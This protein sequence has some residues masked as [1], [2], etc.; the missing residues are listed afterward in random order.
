MPTKK[1]PKDWPEEDF[2]TRRIMCSGGMVK[3]VHRISS[4]FVERGIN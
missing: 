4:V 3:Y 1:D 2:G